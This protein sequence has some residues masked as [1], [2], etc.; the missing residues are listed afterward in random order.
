MAAIDPGV[1]PRTDRRRLVD[2]A[3]ASSAPLRGRLALYD[4][5]VEPFDLRRWVID[6]LPAGHGLVVDVGCGPGL[7]LSELA[8]RGCDRRLGV[9]LSIGMCREATAHATT[10]VA[11]AT[12][13]PLASAS[14]EV[15]IAA[16]MLYHVADIDAALHE[17]GRVLT[18][19]G[20]LAIVLNGSRHLHEMY[21]LLT[22]S[23]RS[24]GGPNEVRGRTFMRSVIDDAAPRVER[25]FTNVRV[26]QFERPIAA[27]DPEVVVAY[28]A[29]LESLYGDVGAPW[30]EVLRSAR[31]RVADHI[32]AHGA[33]T[34]GTHGGVV[35]ASGPRP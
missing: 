35:L 5:I 32:A 29:T 11:D 15:V 16:H 34:T 4:C 20:T 17:F 8:A 18:P 24:L 33:W 25:H 13:L 27:P 26:E 12:A 3:Y 7:Y 2:H 30:A 22:E 23:V 9:D 14:A 31:K 21:E 19:H 10:L 6:Q 1:D 28:L